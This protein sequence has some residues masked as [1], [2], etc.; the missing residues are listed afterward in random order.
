MYKDM[1]MYVDI[2]MYVDMCMYVKFAGFKFIKL[3]LPAGYVLWWTF[4][5]YLYVDCIWK[6]EKICASLL[7]AA[8]IQ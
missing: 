2:C 1:D 3:L 5:I 7:A 6:N 4:S 8:D